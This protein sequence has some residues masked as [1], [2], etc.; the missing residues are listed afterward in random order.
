MAFSQNSLGNRSEPLKLAPAA[1]A[2][3]RGAR[4]MAPAGPGR[5][6][7]RVAGLG[8]RAAP[9][10]AELLRAPPWSARRPRQGDTATGSLDLTTFPAYSH[11]PCQDYFQR[12]VTNWRID[13]MGGGADMFSDK[14]VI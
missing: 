2:G 10:R 7:H 1:A 11:Q 9:P 4:E 12:I 13:T 8:G 6:L 3:P 5:L 14:S